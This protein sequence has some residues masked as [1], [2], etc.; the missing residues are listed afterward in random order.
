MHYGQD[1]T[2]PEFDN[3]WNEWERTFLPYS[4]RA[5]SLPR[6]VRCDTP[7]PSIKRIII[8]QTPPK[9]PTQTSFLS[10]SPR[11]YLVDVDAPRPEV[12]LRE[13]DLLHQLLV[14]LGHVVE[15]EDAPAEGEEEVGAEGDEDPEGELLEW[16]A[17]F[18]SGVVGGRQGVR[19]TG[20]IS[21]WIVAGRGM[22]LR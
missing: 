16:L 10:P 1:T 3:P 4:Q 18:G 7:I 17:L 12:L 21:V 22:R 9:T 19:T 11:T 5:L 14:G 13:V 20:T 15:G 6:T 8:I 2:G